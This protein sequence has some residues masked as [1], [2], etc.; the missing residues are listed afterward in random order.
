MPFEV[1]PDPIESVHTPPSNRCQAPG[2][3]SRA[4]EQVS[5][6]V[7]AAKKGLPKLAG[8]FNLENER[9]NASMPSM[10]TLI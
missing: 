2:S 1:G 8:P 6:R 10:V 5:T 3:P 7:Q 9:V 4:Q